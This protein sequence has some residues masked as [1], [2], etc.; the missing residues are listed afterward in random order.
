VLPGGV[1]KV[2]RLILPAM[3]SPLLQ[4]WAI[5]GH[6][7]R[8]RRCFAYGFEKREWEVVNFIEQFLCACKREEWLFSGGDRAGT[9]F[10]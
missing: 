2:V 7:H 9:A 6:D 1:L 4:R 3:L 10:Q 5:A 8:L